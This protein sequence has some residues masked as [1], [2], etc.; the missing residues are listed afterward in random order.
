MIL[1]ENI[2]VIKKQNKMTLT[3]TK[4]TIEKANKT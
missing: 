2:F 3:E 4:N 1:N